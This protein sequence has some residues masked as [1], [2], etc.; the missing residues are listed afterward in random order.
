MKLED[1]K[2]INANLDLLI[3]ELNKLEEFLT[4]LNLR[5]RKDN[6]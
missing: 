5:I 4:D 6:E 1:L 2:T 3:L